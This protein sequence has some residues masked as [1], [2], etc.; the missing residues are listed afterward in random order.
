MI[1]ETQKLLDAGYSPNLQS[2]QGIGYHQAINYLQ[3]QISY[4]QMIQD[5]QQTTYHLAK[6]QRTWF[7]RYIA[8]AQNNPQKKVKYQLYTIDD[9]EK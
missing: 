4:E 2:M 1:Q 6:K 3:K 8:D 9:E 7:R 5:I